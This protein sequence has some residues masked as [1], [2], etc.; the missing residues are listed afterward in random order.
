MY[1]GARLEKELNARRTG[2]RKES[3]T[4]S[5]STSAAYLSLLDKVQL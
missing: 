4:M 1:K 3:Q 5:N 2:L